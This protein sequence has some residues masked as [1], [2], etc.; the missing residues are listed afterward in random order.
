MSD[1]TITLAGP[2]GTV[3]VGADSLAQARSRIGAAWPA[4]FPPGP[5]AEA[6]ALEVVM[7]EVAEGLSCVS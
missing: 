4:L 6:A 5:E 1:V 2:H 7:T 3:T